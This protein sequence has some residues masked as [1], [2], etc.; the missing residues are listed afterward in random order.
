MEHFCGSIGDWLPQFSEPAR[1]RFRNPRLG[2][3]PSIPENAA[4]QLQDTRSCACM[5]GRTKLGSR[6]FPSVGECIDRI[7]REMLR[8]RPVNRK[9]IIRPHQHRRSVPFRMLNNP[10]GPNFVMLASSKPGTQNLKSKVAHGVGRNEKVEIFPGASFEL[11]ITS[12]Q[13]SSV[14]CLTHKVG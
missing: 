5:Q 10:R 3:S 14:H 12:P 9:P 1:P 8:R 13:P 7:V 6:N 11:E 4:T 2:V